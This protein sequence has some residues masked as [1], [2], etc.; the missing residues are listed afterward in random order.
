MKKLINLSTDKWDL[1]KFAGDYRNIENF[2]IRNNIDGL[3]IIQSIERWNPEKI[4]KKFIKGQHMTFWP[5][6]LDFWRE[7]NTELIRQFGNKES[8]EAYYGGTNKEIL[9]ERY[10]EEL[11]SAKAM[12]A[13]YVV[14]HVSHVQLEHSYTWDFSYS[15]LEVIEAFIDLLN[16]ALEGLEIDFDILLENLWWPGLNMLNQ[17]LAYKLVKEINYDKV[18]FVL[19][20]GHMMIT[21]PNLISEKESVKYLLEKVDNLGSLKSLIK[22]VHLNSSLTGDYIKKFQKGLIPFNKEAS[23]NDNFF[24]SF[25]HI[26]NIDKH[27]PFEDSEITKVIQIIKPDFLVYELISDSL[28]ELEEKVKIQNRTIKNATLTFTDLY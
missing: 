28:E 26:S 17:D 23:F 11:L 22:T 12:E 8:Y 5:I 15:D 10:R 9:I 4:P 24:N 19:D 1:E 21:N 7:K 6:W 2:L 3:E 20:I 18:G 14:F 16:K 27:E 13:E 25:K